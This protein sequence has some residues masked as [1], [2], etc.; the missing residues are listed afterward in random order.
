M[1]FAVDCVAGPA[2]VEYAEHGGLR[3]EVGS[4][5]KVSGRLLDPVQGRSEPA[6]H[7]IR[8]G[9]DNLYSHVNVAHGRRS[10]RRPGNPGMV[11]SNPAA[12]TCIDAQAVLTGCRSF[13]VGPSQSGHLASDRT[14]V[15]KRSRADETSR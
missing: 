9:H 1:F 8:T 12:Y 5:R 4:R 13:E 10:I 14:S 15:A 3:L 11:A 2:P 7:D 6:A